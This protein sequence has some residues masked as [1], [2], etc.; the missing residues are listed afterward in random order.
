MCRDRGVRGPLLEL[1]MDGCLTFCGPIRRGAS[2]QPECLLFTRDD[3]VM[4]HVMQALQS[5]CTS[6]VTVQSS[7]DS[8]DSTIL[9][10]TADLFSTGDEASVRSSAAA[11]ADDAS[12]HLSYTAAAPLPS[13]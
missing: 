2:A 1:R 9:R 8:S 11:A 7:T 5:M 10:S 13:V 12:S 4:A 6:T 3:S